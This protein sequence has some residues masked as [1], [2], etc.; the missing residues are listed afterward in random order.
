LSSFVVLP[1]SKKSSILGIEKRIKN[2]LNVKNKGDKVF[3]GVNF[4]FGFNYRTR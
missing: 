1:V 4:G 3:E 2:S